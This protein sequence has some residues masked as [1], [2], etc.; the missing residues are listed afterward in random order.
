M[1]TSNCSGWWYRD[2]RN[3]A[4]ISPS[5]WVCFHNILTLNWSGWSR[6]ASRN[7]HDIIKNDVWCLQGKFWR[8]SR[9]CFVNAGLWTSIL[10]CSARWILAWCYFF[11]QMSCGRATGPQSLRCAVQ[12]ENCTFFEDVLDQNFSTILV[13][14]AVFWSRSQIPRNPRDGGISGFGSVWYDFAYQSDTQRWIDNPWHCSYI[15]M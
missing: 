5:D 14:V 11:C 15:T 2:V 13:A 7:S 4:D 10:M 9:K 12:S 3:G 6:Q 8:C 1:L